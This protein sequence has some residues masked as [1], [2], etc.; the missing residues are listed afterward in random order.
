[1]TEASSWQA[2]GALPHVFEACPVLLAPLCPPAAVP[3]LAWA[4]LPQH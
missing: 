2:F 3:V 1:M 4:R